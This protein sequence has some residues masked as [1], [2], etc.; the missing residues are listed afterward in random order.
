MDVKDKLISPMFR[1]SLSLYRNA[2]KGL[3]TEMWWLALVMFINRSGTMV[4][5]FLTIYLTQQGYSLA[6]AGYVMGAFGVGAILGSFIG[7]VL[8]DKAGHFFVQVISLF[9]SGIMFI[10]LGQMEGL[11]QI[12]S[13]IFILS[14]IGEAFRPANSAAIA[15]Y[16][17][18]SNRTRCYSLNRLA[19]NLG[20]AF[21]PAIGGL[22]ASRSYALL[23]VVDGLTC[24]SAAAL[25]YFLFR[26]KNKTERNE[27]TVFHSPL[28]VVSAYRDKFFLSGIAL[29][30]LIGLC[31]FQTFSILPV[32]YKERVLL[33]EATIGWLLALNGLLIAVVEMALVYKL[34]NRRDPMIY[35]VAGSVFI[36]LSFLVMNIYPVL[37]IMVLSM[38]II[39]FGE[40]LLFP[41]MN[42]FWVQRSTDSN[43]GQYAALYTMAFS[44]AIVL[45]P[46][47]ASQIATR[48]GYAVLW[49][50]DFV[51]CLFAA[52]GFYYLKKRIHTHERIPEIHSD[53]LVGS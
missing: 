41:F 27:R 24:M 43:R 6:E 34:E 22:L 10:V 16:S 8:T 19:I 48:Q 18:K 20:W 3:S 33:N 52:I 14:T 53:P 35:M 46:T 49:T 7:G 32:F 13:C 47:I 4:I 2:Y 21:G 29:L 23:F 50:V 9:L 5:P 31:F 15:S 45:A 12:T 40:M 26:K 38:V 37:S 28:P 42:N 30:F 36:G 39:T 1:S 44:A 51:L 11:F 17:N 25:L